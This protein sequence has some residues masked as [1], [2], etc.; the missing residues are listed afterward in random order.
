MSTMSKYKFDDCSY[1]SDLE[2]LKIPKFQ[3]GLV[4][5]KDKKEA[6]LQTIHDGFPFGALL[7]YD[8]SSNGKESMLLLDGQQR[9]STIIEYDENKFTYW[10]KLNPVKYQ[11]L[12]EN[13]NSIIGNENYYVDDKKLNEISDENFDLGSW[14]DELDDLRLG[15]DNKEK[16]RNL[17][18]SA[19]NDVRDYIDLDSLRIPLIKYTG[20]REYLPVVFENLNKGGV[21]LSKYEVFNASWNDEYLKLPDNDYTREIISN[22]KKYYLNMQDN[23]EFDVSDF[24]EDD[25]TN[26]KKVNL[27]EFARAFG[28][29]TVERI[30]SLISKRDKEK[31]YNEIGY[32]LLAVICGVSNLKIMNI[33]DHVNWIRDNVTDIL[34]RTSVISN[35]LNSSFDKLL[36]QIISYDVSRNAK[37]GDYSNGLSG[38]FKILSYYANLWDA[39]EKSTK[40][41]LKNIPAYYIYD[42]FNYSWTGHGD[43]R[44]NDY[45]SKNRRRTYEIK[46]NK[47]DFISAFENW[48]KDNPGNRKTFSKEIKALITIHSNLTYMAGSIP[49]GEDYEFEHIV[50]KKWIVDKNTSQQPTNLSSIG[51]GMFL[52]K[53]TNNRKR[54]KTL[55]EFKGYDDKKYSSFI[56]ESSYPS[57]ETLEKAKEYAHYRDYDNINKI[58]NGRT[59]EVIQS[60]SDH[61]FN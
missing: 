15:R 9:L 18:I 61:L 45:Y 52:P 53:D 32:G 28:E 20:P 16:L 34:E 14:T 42:S 23:G 37:K 38:S 60:I 43:S 41:I 39:D 48:V 22:V 49:S 58:I 11:S 44:L 56:S 3:R 4:W 54:D 6:L 1:K 27:A 50:P 57:N 8:T 13:I 12:K 21:P 7:V 10:S 31:A 51:N 26:S 35:K 25:I 59:R 5:S 29:F 40:E 2:N 36:K 17:V 55:Y 33:K 19:R 46:L 24:S 47:S 30:P